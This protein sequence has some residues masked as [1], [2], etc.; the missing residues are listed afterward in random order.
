[1]A[2]SFLDHIIDQIKDETGRT[3][4]HVKNLK[5]VVPVTAT[6]DANIY[7]QEWFVLRVPTLRLPTLREFIDQH[8]H[9]RYPV[10]E[11]DGVGGTTTYPSGSNP[12]PE[13][14]YGF[15]TE[16]DLSGPEVFNVDVSTA[17]GQYA[18]YVDGGNLGSGVNA[19][20]TSVSL[21]AG[22]YRLAI[23]VY[24]ATAPMSI[25][26]PERIRCSRGNDT[27]DAPLW[28]KD[29]EAQY[30]QPQNGSY[31]VELEWNN[32]PH[33]AEWN[34]Y[35]ADSVPLT[36]PA[37]ITFPSPNTTVLTYS[38]AISGLTKGVYL[39]TDTFR[40][41]LVTNVEETRDGGGTV[42]LTTITLL[43]HPDAPTDSALWAGRSYYMSSQSF[44]AIGRVAYAGTETISYIDT[45][46]RGLTPYF[47]KL[48]ALS[49]LSAT[50]ESDFSRVAGVF[51][52]DTTPPGNI[53][54]GTIYV[55]PTSVTV[56]FTAPVDQDYR[57]VNV[58]YVD[59]GTQT[60]VYTESGL[61]GQLDSLIFTPTEVGVYRFRTV[62]WAGNIQATGSGVTWTFDG[63]FG[64]NTRLIK[65]KLTIIAEPASNRYQVAISVFDAV[66]IVAADSYTVTLLPQGNI[67]LSNVGPILMT[68]GTSPVIFVTPPP[69]GDKTG[70]LTATITATDRTPDDDAVDI[71]ALDR[72][73]ELPLRATIDLVTLTATTTQATLTYS[74]PPSS[75]A[76]WARLFVQETSNYPGAAPTHVDT[77]GHRIPSGDLYRS[78][79]VRPITIDGMLG[80]NWLTITAVPYDELN[81]E[82][83]RV[84]RT[85]QLLTPVGAPPA[86]VD[87]R[88]TSGTT[89]ETSITNEV[90]LPTLNVTYSPYH[91]RAFVDNVAREV[92]DLSG[93][94]GVWVPITSNGL[95][96]GTS[97]SFKYAIYNSLGQSVYSNTI[98]V[99]TQSASSL[100]APTF[101]RLSPNFTGHIYIQ[102]GDFVVN[103]GAGWPA[104]TVIEIERV[105]P[106]PAAVLATGA[107][108]YYILSFIAEVGGDY[109]VSLR[110]RG[111]TP[112]GVVS[113]WVTLASFTVP[114][115]SGTYLI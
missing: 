12:L 78:V 110:A 93:T 30:L 90:L 48:T 58:Y 49:Y 84:T 70:R 54:L 32:D 26:V 16:I 23:L 64:D 20:S 53:T 25:T 15:I 62:D 61:P 21:N 68:Y 40:I 79:P 102:E 65:T 43:A 104:G 24:G 36:T 52:N 22:T 51:V 42:T 72:N 113:T 9:D 96:G 109:S 114:Y 85:I 44:T 69:W 71:P 17:A 41:G 19:G 88:A 115:W 73:T 74:W 97:Y 35:R 39:V 4:A 94:G 60:L 38:S 76:A 18:V 2:K 101:L 31:Q 1:M 100:T 111:R 6:V 13:F 7:P 46:V 105:S 28:T 37:S 50:V 98:L 75:L 89:T 55:G 99:S 107:P 56:N 27:P 59:G 34:V 82:G 11:A 33:A 67:T 66:P 83:V 63:V 57:A 112:A 80:G 95:T 92:V 29:P 3:P 5:G 45:Q 87:V 106:S 108:G 47:Y 81:R 77:T 14:T 103:A 10:G 91:L 8:S 86:P